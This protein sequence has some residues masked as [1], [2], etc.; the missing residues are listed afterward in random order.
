MA[1][2]LEPP[3]TRHLPEPL[4]FWTSL[5]KRK[6]R[7]FRWFLLA[8]AS[9]LVSAVIEITGST[10][11]YRFRTR[12]P[13]SV[14]RSGH[15]GGQLAGSI[16]KKVPLGENFDLRVG[17]DASGHLHGSDPKFIGFKA[18]DPDLGFQNHQTPGS[19]YI[20]ESNKTR[21]LNE[22]N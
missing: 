11:A 14:L 15:C 4:R 6:T 7:I 8:F 12:A 1:S 16:A 9:V 21:S 20:Q 3:D 17:S 13:Q 19:A 18:D 22:I 2:I 5:K 10:G